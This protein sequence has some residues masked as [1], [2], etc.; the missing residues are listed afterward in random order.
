MSFDGVF[1]G[2]FELNLTKKINGINVRRTYAI[3]S[4][5]PKS[6]RIDIPGQFSKVLVEAGRTSENQMIDF[7]FKSGLF[8]MEIFC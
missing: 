3:V 7:C 4:S 2:N 8:Y 6:S 1:F 5:I